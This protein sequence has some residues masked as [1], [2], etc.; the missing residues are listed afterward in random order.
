MVNAGTHYVIYERSFKV[1]VPDFFHCQTAKEGDQLK[2][3]AKAPTR[4]G[5][6]FTSIPVNNSIWLTVLAPEQYLYCI[7]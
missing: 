6:L 4:A 5:S 3:S 7:N 2:L 1:S